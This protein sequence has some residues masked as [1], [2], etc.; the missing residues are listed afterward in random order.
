MFYN[1][2]RMK[3]DLSVIVVPQVVWF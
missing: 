3:L 2:L 1:S